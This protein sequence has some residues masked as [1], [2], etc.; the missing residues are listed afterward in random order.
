MGGRAAKL[1]SLNIVQR[2]VGTS[3]GLKPKVRRSH[4]IHKD[5]LDS[6][7]EGVAFESDWR[8]KLKRKEM[9]H[10]KRGVHL[11][12]PSRWNLQELV[13]N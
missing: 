6:S 3:K 1:R 12:A 2:S 7:M 4:Y 9:G 11:R 8:Q 5:P 13:A 10:R